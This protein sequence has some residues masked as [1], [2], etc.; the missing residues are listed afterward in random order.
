[1][2]ARE[3]KPRREKRRMVP[4]MVVVLAG[5]GG[6]SALVGRCSFPRRVRYGM[7]WYGMEEETKQRGRSESVKQKL[8]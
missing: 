5:L 8:P 6:V 4:N 7:V 2:A 1:M 3:R